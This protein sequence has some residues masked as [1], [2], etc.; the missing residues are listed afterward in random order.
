MTD[1]YSEAAGKTGPSWDGMIN[2]VIQLCARVRVRVR[3]QK[4]RTLSIEY[5]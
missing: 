1:S 2:N 4:A 3:L 5:E